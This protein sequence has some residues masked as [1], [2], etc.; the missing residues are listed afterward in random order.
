MNKV[1]FSVQYSA[2]NRLRPNWFPREGNCQSFRSACNEPVQG[3]PDLQG[4]TE[5]AL[6]EKRNSCWPDAGRAHTGCT[7]AFVLFADSLLTCKEA[8]AP[9]KRSRY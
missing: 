6:V 3:A 2:P 1:F 5:I 7:H 9:V 4:I 8:L